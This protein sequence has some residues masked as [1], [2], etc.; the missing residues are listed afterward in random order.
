MH[1]EQ[2]LAEVCVSLTLDLN[3]SLVVFG[4]SFQIHNPAEQQQIFVLLFDELVI[5]FYQAALGGLG[6][7]LKTFN[8]FLETGDGFCESL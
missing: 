5:N 7:I 4:K 1:L 8:V 6:C 3:C 2:Q